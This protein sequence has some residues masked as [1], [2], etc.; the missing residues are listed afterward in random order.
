M[1]HTY[2]PVRKAIMKKNIL[3]EDIVNTI[4]QN[5]KDILSHSNMQ[6]EKDFIQH[7]TVSCYEH[8]LCVTYLSLWLAFQTP[9]HW[10]Y[11]SIVR[12][13]LL[14][15][16]YLYDW[17]IREQ[18]LR[19]HGFRHPKRAL[20]NAMVNFH[21]NPIEMDIIRKHMFPLTPIPPKY[22][23][24]ILVTCA[25]KL[26]ALAETFGGKHMSFSDNL[27][28]TRK[29]RD[30]SQEQLADLLQVSRQA[31]SKW[32]QGIG[33]PETETLIQIA[34]T[35]DVSLDYLLL[36]KSDISNQT[37]DV[38]NKAVGTSLS[39][40]KIIIAS[41]NQDTIGS[42]FK[43]TIAKLP[44][45]DS[46]DVKATL[47]GVHGTSFLGD[48]SDVLGY[49]TEEADA[50]KE[51]EDILAALIAGETSYKLKYNVPVKIGLFTIKKV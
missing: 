15:D 18:S 48:K 22:K 26:C 41:H 45:S 25:D 47:S 11:P 49:Y 16:Y 14:H 30:L 34:K 1:S 51:L 38:D 44:F 28:K 21:L 12:G 32:E 24:S 13:A 20:D 17:H 5:G 37:E 42:Y 43:F 46:D 50:K 10:D 33:Y 4:I 8:S 36:N 19:L 40:R 29:D 39:D 7:G 27:R 3:H 23:E 9:F 31:I 35:L 2:H 6:K